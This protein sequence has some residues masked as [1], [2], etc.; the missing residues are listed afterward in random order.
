MDSRHWGQCSPQG[1]QGSLGVLSSAPK[2]PSCPLP[3]ERRQGGQ[4]WPS[5]PMPCL[6]TGGAQP[7]GGPF[8][9]PVASAARTFTVSSTSLPDLPILQS[10]ATSKK[11]V[12]Y[13]EII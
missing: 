1:A 4:G 8:L 13:S 6:Q 12:Y 3:G 9:N 2:A 5:L 7:W 11:E 10:F